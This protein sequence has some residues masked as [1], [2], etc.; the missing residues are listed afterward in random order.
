MNG[1]RHPLHD[2][3]LQVTTPGF[4][5]WYA[6][7]AV[8]ISQTTG[9]R[10]TKRDAEEITHL[11]DIAIEER[12]EDVKRLG[13]LL[14]V[15]DWRSLKGYDADARAFMMD[16]LRSHTRGRIREM[17]IAIEMSPLFQL[18]LGA[19]NAFLVLATGKN[20]RT[21]SAV[22]PELIR[23]GIKKPAEGSRFPGPLRSSIR[24]PRSGN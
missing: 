24:V 4:Y 2:W 13:G 20:L 6:E 21:V 23:Y 14:I 8:F 10:G 16:R 22:A 12:G 15:H 11:V 19:A 9:D 7:P 5:A 18:A 17:V 3:P 1:P